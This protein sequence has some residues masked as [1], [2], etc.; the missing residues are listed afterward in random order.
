MSSL[1]P[2]DVELRRAARERALE[3]LYEAEIKGL[4]VEQLLTSLSL[5]PAELAVELVRGVEA[6]RAEI[7]ALLERRV[8]P[9]WSL[10]RLAVVDRAIL[11]LATYELLG[12]P[13]RSEAIILNEAVVL[14]RRFGS[15]DT[16]RFVNGVLSAVAAD[17]RTHDGEDRE[18]DPVAPA[19]PAT[20]GAPAKPAVDGLIMDLDGVIRHWDQAAV[21][22]GDAEL[23]V[24]SGTIAAAAFEPDLLKRAMRG[25]LTADEWYAAAGAVVAGKH[26]VDAGAAGRVMAEVGWSIDESVME[27]VDR[28]R[29]RVPV[30]LLSNASTRLREDLE[31][32]GIAERF[33]AV[34]SSAEIGV[35]KPEPEA[36]EAAAKAL[37]VEPGRCMMVDDREENVAGAAAAGMH[38]VRFTSGEDL[39]RHL[40]AAG[41][42]DLVT[43][44]STHIHSDPAP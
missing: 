14:A 3:I 4:P 31:T 15:D 33:D 24:P 42:I 27:L 43:D 40:Q 32:S 25:E 6:H 18:H 8:A 21:T 20:R 34:I 5:T 23:G 22:A 12:A 1:E 13:Q 28:T 36:Y 26:G 2:D 30:A 17:V 44:D 10:P 7:D 16:P 35:I 39:A 9:S 38:A 41:L 19:T 29:R 37:G 11:R